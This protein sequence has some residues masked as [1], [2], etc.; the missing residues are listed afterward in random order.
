MK[1]LTEGRLSEEKKHFQN[2]T[3]NISSKLNLKKIVLFCGPQLNPIELR[4]QFSS[5]RLIR[6]NYISTKHSFV[7]MCAVVF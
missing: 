7:L 3:S 5:R 6:K 4:G 2:F 1:N